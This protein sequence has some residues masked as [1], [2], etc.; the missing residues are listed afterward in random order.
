MHRQ[1]AL[2]FAPT[3]ETRMP[4]IVGIIVIFMIGVVMKVFDAVGGW[5]GVF[6]IVAGLV[7]GG[8]A[9]AIALKRSDEIK[10]LKAKPDRVSSLLK[11]AEALSAADPEALLRDTLAEFEAGRAPLFW[12]NFDGC[13]EGLWTVV[14]GLDRA[15]EEADAYKDGARKYGLFPSE[16]KLDDAEREYRDVAEMYRQALIRIRDDAP[17]SRP[18]RLM[19]TMRVGVET[20]ARSAA[21]DIRAPSLHDRADV[22]ETPRPHVG[23][24][25]VGK[26]ITKAETDSGQWDTGVGTPLSKARLERMCSGPDTEPTKH[27]RQGVCRNGS[28]KAIG[29]YKTVSTT[30]LPGLVEDAENMTGERAACRGPLFLPLR[31]SPPPAPKVEV[32]PACISHLTRARGSQDKKCKSESRR[33]RSIGPTNCSEHRPDLGMRKCTVGYRVRLSAEGGCDQVKVQGVGAVS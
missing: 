21:K 5:P 25:R 7:G 18:A 23:E 11:P 24:V 15:R 30:E 10:A 2:E 12:E 16:I 22:V 14:D 3:R 31:D 29:K 19:P 26:N 17:R 32:V 1:L 28:L 9:L 20:I 4:I 33:W 13:C 6:L 8:Y 27:R